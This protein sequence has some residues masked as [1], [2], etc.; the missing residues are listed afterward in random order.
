MQ[1]AT[2]TPGPGQACRLII[3]AASPRLGSHSDAPACQHLVDR[4]PASLQR[5]MRLVAPGSFSRKHSLQAV[6]VEKSFVVLIL[7]CCPG[8]S[9]LVS[10]PKPE[11]SP[12]EQDRTGGVSCR[13]QSRRHRRGEWD[14]KSLQE[15]KETIRRKQ[16]KKKKDRDRS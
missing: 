2:R 10:T 5:T 15:E 7:D 1:R 4:S 16:A 9:N 6:G 3:I 13:T 11:P 8:L 14:A 12:N